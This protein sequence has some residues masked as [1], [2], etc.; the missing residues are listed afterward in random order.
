MRARTVSA[1]SVRSTDPRPGSE[2]EERDS[3]A[4]TGKRKPDAAS[5]TATGSVIPFSSPLL[6]I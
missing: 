6:L 3:A 5:D 2:R 1:T 4:L